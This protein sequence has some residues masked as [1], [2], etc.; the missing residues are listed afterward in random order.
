MEKY[1][2]KKYERKMEQYVIKRYERKMR[3]ARYTGV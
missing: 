1:V 2:I 3:S